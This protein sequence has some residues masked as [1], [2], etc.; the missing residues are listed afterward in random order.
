M[1]SAELY[2]EQTDAFTETATVL[3]HELLT[4]QGIITNSSF[5]VPTAHCSLIVRPN[6]ASAHCSPQ[7]LIVRPTY[8]M[9]AAAAAAAA[10]AA[11][12]ATADVAFGF[13]PAAA[14]AV[15]AAAAPAAAEEEVDARTTHRY[16]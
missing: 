2:R 3:R 1:A 13:E 10:A 4:A 9:S 7:Q 12:A 16:K 5:F 14:A 15:A 8:N 6:Q 11:R